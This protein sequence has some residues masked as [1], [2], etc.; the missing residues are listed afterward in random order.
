MSATELATIQASGFY[1]QDAAANLLVAIPWL[2]D[3]GDFISLVAVA[4]ALPVFEY[5][6]GK[7]PILL[8]ASQLGTAAFF[9]NFALTAVVFALRWTGALPRVETS[10]VRLESIVWRPSWRFIVGSLLFW[11]CVAIALIALFTF[12]PAL[13]PDQRVLKI[14]TNVSPLILLVFVWVAVMV[15]MRMRQR[16]TSNSA[17]RDSLSALDR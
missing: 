3:S 14:V 7:S 10:E 12:A 9:G 11:I 4:I 6:F 16:R 8:L 13:V 15:S 1:D 5:R 2:D 17:S